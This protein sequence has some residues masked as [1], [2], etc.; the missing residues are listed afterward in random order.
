MA[1]GASTRVRP[2]GRLDQPTLIRAFV[3]MVSHELRT[4][5]QA[6]VADTDTMSLLPLSPRARDRLEDLSRSL[7][8]AIERLDSTSE[9]LL[10]STAAAQPPEG[11]FDLE[12]ELATLVRLHEAT[13]VA[14][15][16]TLRLSMGT[17]LPSVLRCDVDALRVAIS[18]FVED[19]LEGVVEPGTI[20]IRVLPRTDPGN[21]PTTEFVV[22][23]V[24]GARSGSERD[25][26]ASLGALIAAG[27]GWAAGKRRVALT[28]E[29]YVEVPNP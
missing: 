18:L 21:R 3:G 20:E 15:R 4:P 11:A 8:C 6:L 14:R 19:A 7:T 24:D 26:A 22:A 17:N 13:A 27:A 12:A 1:S 28:S 29:H 10:R 2:S 16:A 9:Y 5:L 25:C 23:V